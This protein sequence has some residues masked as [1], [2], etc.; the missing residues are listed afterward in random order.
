MENYNLNVQQQI[1]S[2]VVLQVGYV[3]AQG[4]RLLHYLDLNQPSQAAITASDL[5]T[6]RRQPRCFMGHGALPVAA[7][8]HHS[9]VQRSAALRE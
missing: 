6:A 3:G 2:K 8:L 7:P 9:V 4:H 1:S 5:A